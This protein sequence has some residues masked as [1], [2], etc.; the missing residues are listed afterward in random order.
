MGRFR[1]SIWKELITLGVARQRCYGC[2]MPGNVLSQ[3]GWGFDQPC[4]V[5]GVPAYDREDG[6]R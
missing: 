2:P 6:I 3:A 1:L 5:V 4:L